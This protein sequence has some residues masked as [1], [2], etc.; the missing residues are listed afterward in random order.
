MTWDT[1]LGSADIAHHSAALVAESIVARQTSAWL[2]AYAR[3]LRHES[4][5]L[6]LLAGILRDVA[7]AQR[8]AGGEFR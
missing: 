3:E 4:V 7:I 8:N 5:V 2:T 1:G 6:I